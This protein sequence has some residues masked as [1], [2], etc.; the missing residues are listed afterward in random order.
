[1]LLIQ[2]S[3]PPGDIDPPRSHRDQS[4]QLVVLAREVVEA[5]LSEEHDTA[6]AEH[7]VM[8]GPLTFLG[9]REGGRPFSIHPEHDIV[10]FKIDLFPCELI[11]EEAE[12][13]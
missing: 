3:I 6:P 7:V 12:V 10:C 11:L 9:H 2:R 8:E 5:V 13:G 4:G 1:M